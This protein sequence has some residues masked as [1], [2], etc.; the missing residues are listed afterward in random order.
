MKKVLNIVPYQFLPFF[1]GG[2]KLI[3]QFNE[4]LGNECSLF[5]IGTVGNDA[6]L[7]KK[8]QF[9]PLLKKS[10]LRYMDV[11]AFFSIR[12]LIKE[13]GI[14]TILIEHPYL[15]WLGWLLKKAT[16]ARLIVHTHNIEYERF[17]TVG[18]PWWPLLKWY[19][20]TVLR[21]ADFVFCISDEDRQW[22]ISRMQVQP[23]LCAVVP[24][25]IAQEQIPNDKAEC[26]EQVYNRH[27]IDRSKTLLFFNGLLDYKPNTDAL[28]TIIEKINPLLQQSNLNY[29][30]LVAG[31]RLPASFN[32]LKQWNK[33]NISYAGFVDDIDLYTK[34]AD[35]LLNPVTSGGGVK[36]KMIEAI[37]LNTTVVATETGAVGVNRSSCGSKLKVVADNNWQKFSETAI[38]TVKEPFFNTPASFFTTY[39]WKMIIQ[40]VVPFL[41]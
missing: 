12:K 2:Q 34:A 39:N 28:L 40:R 8:Y 31:K 16:G 10:R 35:V 19:E 7:A 33:E 14:D 21:S 13:A 37:G 1:S 36:T 24:Y 18:K 30:I 9:Y 32:E 25:G 26:K 5:V 15:G 20:T 41:K 29:H 27:H 6:T 22:M 17:R 4:H 11:T 23:E 38:Q 3:A